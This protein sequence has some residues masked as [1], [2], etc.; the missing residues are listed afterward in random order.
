[1]QGFAG[2]RQRNNSEIFYKI[3]SNTQDKDEMLISSLFFMENGEKLKCKYIY[4][5]INKSL[6]ALRNK[7]FK[8]N[9]FH[10]S[11]DK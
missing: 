8:K 2:D 9:I 6:Q 5:K 10:Q 1:V 11:V 4:I 7:D 3:S